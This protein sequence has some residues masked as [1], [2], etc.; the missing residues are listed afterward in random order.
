MAPTNW[1]DRA[2]QLLQRSSTLESDLY[3]SSNAGIIRKAV[4]GIG[5]DSDR[6]H[7]SGGVRIVFNISSAHA[8][9]I[10]SRRYR[11]GY[12]LEEKDVRVGGKPPAAVS[13]RRR[14]IDN[15]VAT[16]GSST[17]KG[18]TL[19]Y[20]ALELNGAGMRYYGDLCLVLREAALGPS[21]LLLYRNSYD[22]DREPIR[23]RVNGVEAKLRLEAR[24][25][26]G[27]GS[28]AADMVICK[29]LTDAAPTTRLMTTGLISEGVL[30]DEDYLEVPLEQS[31]GAAELCEIRTA[32][33]DVAAEARIGS[34]LEQGPPP[35]L[36][37]LLWRNRRRDA[38]RCASDLDL[39]IRIV[40]SQGRTR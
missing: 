9:K 37:E 26:A 1:A 7:L 34:R 22:L 21:T 35:T 11:N 28:D 20:G 27:H 17:A 13:N 4:C 10:L 12:E 30:A 29:I 25:L 36:A 23:S 5:L 8:R 14:R 15:M 40:S 33:G 38:E 16:L 18:E 24:A 2:D 19:Y 31:F 39:P 6:K 3:R 32:S